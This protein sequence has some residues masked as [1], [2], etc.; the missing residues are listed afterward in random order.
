MLTSNIFRMMRLRTLHNAR[1]FFFNLINSISCSITDLSFAWNSAYNT[2]IQNLVLPFDFKLIV[3]SWHVEVVFLE[4][5]VLVILGLR[6]AQIIFATCPGRK[7]TKLFNVILGCLIIS[8]Y[9]TYQTL[10][11]AVLIYRKF[12]DLIP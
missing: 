6:S 1:L 3:F 12:H 10:N 2:S 5:L 9:L 4:W 8:L 7:Q 11:S